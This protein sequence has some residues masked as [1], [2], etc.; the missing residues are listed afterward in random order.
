[1]AWAVWGAATLPA[2]PSSSS[3]S[4]AAKRGS[5]AVPAKQQQKGGGSGLARLLQLP[6]ST[7]VQLGVLCY[8]HAVMGYC[9]F[10]LQNWIPTFLASF[11]GSGQGI[12]VTGGLSS[13][14]WIAA[15]VVGPLAG[16]AANN[17]IKSGTMGQ[18]AVR[19]L[20]QVCV[21]DFLGGTLFGG[22][23]FVGGGTLD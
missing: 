15:A 18:L 19:R 13:I 8:S 3:S 21:Q 9:F 2:A 4:S 14:P 5:A 1:M 22:G 10:I 7:L 17:L 20:M 12:A 23:G 6:R 11:G 16:Q